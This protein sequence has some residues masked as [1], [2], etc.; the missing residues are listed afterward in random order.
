MTNSYPLTQGTSLWLEIFDE[1]SLISF[2]IS[3]LLKGLQRTNVFESL[4]CLSAPLVLLNKVFSEIIL[5]IFFVVAYWNYF[6]YNVR[7]LYFVLDSSRITF[8]LG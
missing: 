7:D 2:Q 3:L 5:K 1:S 4:L 8:R 6:W